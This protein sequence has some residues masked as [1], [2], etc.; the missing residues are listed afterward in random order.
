MAGKK[1]PCPCG[2]RKTYYQCCGKTSNVI[3]LTQFRLRKVGENLRRK[4]GDYVGRHEF[5]RDAAIAQELYFRHLDVGITDFD[6]DFL[7]ERCFEWFIFDFRLPDG[8]RI[9]DKFKRD[10]S[11]SADEKVLLDGWSRVVNSLYEVKAVFPGKLF[12]ED[13]FSREQLVVA[14]INAVREISPGFILYMRVLPVGNENEFSTSGLALPNNCRNKL[15]KRLFADAFRFWE[16]GNF[17][18]DWKIYLRECSHV[19]N[20]M[21]MQVTVE[22]GLE[23]QD[24]EEVDFPDE[25]HYDHEFESGEQVMIL[26]DFP[27]REVRY[28]CV[29]RVVAEELYTHSYN[30]K[31]VNNALRLWY[32]YTSLERPSFRKP[33]A[34]V[35]TIVYAVSR[36]EQDHRESQNTL[37]ERY[38][39][40]PSTISD[41]YRSM[42]KILGLKDCDDRYSTCGRP[43]QIQRIKNTISFLSHFLF[44]RK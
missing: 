20:S 29:A 14:D 8:D 10:P 22:P 31:Q 28:Q 12:L 4:L 3:S 42:C 40:S 7:M 9:I 24:M 1:I 44:R 43:D 34:W 5:A 36:L 32:D 30:Y 35:A 23:W 19:V 13:L 11:L 15:L 16:K 2:S 21:V 27:W 6:D 18:E 26:E 41:K 37:A 25:E 39:V 17:A 33:E 38:G